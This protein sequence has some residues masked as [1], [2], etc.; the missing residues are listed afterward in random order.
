MMLSIIAVHADEGEQKKNEIEGPVI[1]IDLGTTYS[2]VGIFKNGRVEIIP[3]ELG[4]RITPSYVAF[5][6]DE[7]LVGESAKNQGSLNPLRT[8]YVVKRLIGRKFEDKEVQRDMKMVPYKIISKQGKPYVS[9]N[10]ANG[11]KTL[12]PEEVSAMILTKMKEVAEAYLGREVKHAV[13]TVPA[14][15]N[16]AQR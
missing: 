16:D 4:N 1:G 6:D 9:V 2:C 7:K 5:N 11:D 14:Y 8:I 3:N 15:F 12:S 13:V 10:T